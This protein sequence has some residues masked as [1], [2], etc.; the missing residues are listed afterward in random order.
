[1]EKVLVLDFGGQ[2]GALVARRIRECKVYSELL[3]CTAPIEEIK[4]T[5]YKGIVLT[6]EPKSVY[7]VD[8]PRCDAEIFSLGVPVLGIGYGAQLM[9]QMLGGNVKPGCAE[10][11]SVAM[12]VDNSC[13]LF[14]SLSTKTDCWMKHTDY[15]AQVP[16]GFRITAKTEVCSV[17]AMENSIKR[18]YAVQFHPEITHT[19]FGKQIIKNFLHSICGCHAEWTPAA[20]VRKTVAALEEKIGDRRVLCALSGDVC[21]SVT[22]ALLHRAA[23]DRLTCVSVDHGMLRKGEN[24]QLKSVFG[25]EYGINL[26]SADAGQR[27]LGKLIGITDADAKCKIIE[28]E[29]AR[30]FAAECENLG[31]IDFWA[32]ETIYSDKI[33]GDHKADYLD[34]YIKCEE[35][36]EPLATL[37]EDEV[38]QVGLELGLPSEIVFRQAFPRSGLAG[39]VMGEITAEKLLALREADAIFRE[40]IVSA[41]LERTTNRYFA[42]LTD[43]LSQRT[44]NYTV[45]LRAID[46]DE[47]SAAD[48]S[49]SHLPY[50]VL[51]RAALKIKKVVNGVTRVVYDITADEATPIEW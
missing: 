48:Y 4:L 20:F 33:S 34:D 27:F 23:G 12:A 19:V 46:F 18:L 1:M 16:T 8:A 47:F 50:D 41:H 31:K 24:G 36:L 29:T 43:E 11:G 7:N 32:K 3:P 6:G 28:E 35:K 51:D 39:R 49:W 37:F 40:E 22:A 25:G 9:A 15:I 30:V 2:Y 42:V 21:S 10:N 17:A 13:M 38:R 45:I 5:D 14:S 26:V 44:N